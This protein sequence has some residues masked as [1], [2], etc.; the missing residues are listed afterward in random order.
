MTDIKKKPKNADFNPVKEDLSGVQAKRVI[1]SSNAL[2]LALEG[3]KQGR[4]LVA[5]PFYENNTKLL[6]G[7]LVFD[8]TQEEIQEWLRCKN[9]IIYFVEKYCKLMTPEGIKN[10]KLRD[11]QVNYLRH[12]MDHRLSIYL[13][14]RQCGKTTTS[15]VFMLHYI[16]FN[17]DKNSL[18]LGN[19]RKTAVEILDKAKKIY[20]ELPYFLKPG[21][22]KWNEGE[23][24]LDNGCRLMAEA[25]TIN[26]GISFT[27]HC[28]LA[29]EFAHCPPNILDKFYNNLFP[30]I[31]AAKARFMITSTQNGYN[32]FYRLYKS[33][34]AGDNEYAPFKTDWY[35]VPEWDP[36]NRC[37]AKRDDAWHQL[38][39]A[40]YG[41][42]EAFN[43]QFGTNFD[44]S[45]NTLIAQKIISKRNMRLVE[46]VEKEMPGVPY[47]NAWRWHPNFDPI[48]CRNSF[49]VLTTD[50]A[51]GGGGDSTVCA[52]H[53]FIEPGSNKL[54]CIGYFKSNQLARELATTSIQVFTTLMCHPDRTLLSFERNVYGEIFV[55]QMLENVEKGVHG[56]AM[57]DQSIFVKYYNESGTRFN[58]G[59]KITSGNKTAH[60]MLYKEDYEKDLLINDASQYMVELNNFSDT[61]NGKYAAAFGHDD[62]VMAE[63][64]LTFVR[65]TLQ[66]K[67]L[68]DEFEAGAD[69]AMPDTIYNAFEAFDPFMNYRDV[70]AT[71]NISVNDMYN[72]Y[73]IDLNNMYKRLNNM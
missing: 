63:V 66:Y 17:I 3:I 35:E 24:V 36:E 54:E 73:D 69:I 21:I 41:S 20:L 56:C 47:S 39:V 6:K 10:V 9:D 25:T 58:Y 62:M 34:E 68:R 61:G 18:V 49:L 27:F 2:N 64:Q 28:V 30:T 43:A 60:C 8:R 46:F 33:A 31:T 7:D 15:A 71:N 14:C 1:W 4:K 37:W 26:S 11:Y 38:Q 65:E 55:K 51:E 16:L 45:A 23:I 72:I 13:A 29:D 57:F 32:L 19:K 70:M 44:I 52:V 53:R 12:L 40:N 59:I 22:Y 50:I 67:M 5:N 48:N 42:E